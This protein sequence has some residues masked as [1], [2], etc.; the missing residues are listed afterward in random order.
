MCLTIIDPG[1][2]PVKGD[3]LIPI[4]KVGMRETKSHSI[5]NTKRPNLEKH[6]KWLV[7]LSVRPG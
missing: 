1:S 4:N 5:V 7:P 3:S 2:N 6:L